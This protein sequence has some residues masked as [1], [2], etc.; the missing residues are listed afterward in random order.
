MKVGLVLEGGA[1][2]GMY[3]A[4]V[5][6]VL[7]ENNVRVDGIVGVSAGALFGVN[8][9]SRQI[10]RVIRYNKRFSPDKN[11]IGLWPLLKEGNIVSTQFAY[12]EVPRKL[13]VF[14]DEAFRVSGIPFYAVVTNLQTG[15]GEYLLLESVFEQMDI[16]RAS[17]SMPFV[18]RP[19][20]WQGKRYLDGAIADS[21]PYRWMA[22][23]GYEKRIV[24]LTRQEG[25]RKRPMNQGLC[26]I[27]YRKWPKFVQK[28]LTRHSAYNAALDELQQWRSE[29]KAFVLRPSQEIKIGRVEKDPE[30]LQAVYDLGRK[31]ARAQLAQLQDYL[32]A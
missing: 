30:K 15:E 16:L 23:Q 29:G 17:G 21:I 3:T 2:R 4:G 12:N 28:L 22:E 19:V 20:L 1:M 6:D 9:P 11:Y 13:D 32:Q 5:L 14:D 18:S 7:M 24:V 27:M 31:D 26:K 25:Y 8:Y 10:G